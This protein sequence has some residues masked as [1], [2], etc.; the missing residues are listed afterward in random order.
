MFFYVRWMK[1]SR[2]CSAFSFSRLLDR[3][4][5]SENRREVSEIM[6]YSLITKALRSDLRS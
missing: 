5:L 6:S 1:A 4:S 3:I 2:A